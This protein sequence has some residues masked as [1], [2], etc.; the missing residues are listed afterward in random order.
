MRATKVK[1][2]RAG[3]ARPGLKLRA[4]E[5]KAELREVVVRVPGCNHGVAGDDAAKGV[6]DA[7]VEHDPELRFHPRSKANTARL[8]EP[9]SQPPRWGRR[10][11]VGD[12]AQVL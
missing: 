4:G 9:V 8:V 3:S 10:C 11:K 7:A 2:K 5:T 6:E 12:A 1:P